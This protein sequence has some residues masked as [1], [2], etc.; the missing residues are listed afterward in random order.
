[1]SSFISFIRYNASCGVLLQVR[2]GGSGVRRIWLWGCRGYYYKSVMC[3]LSTPLARTEARG[4]GEV[5][6][7]RG[8]FSGR[9]WIRGCLTRGRPGGTGGRGWSEW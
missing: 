5:T 4:T 8:L 1:M 7:S 6:V 2:S 9:A 3:W